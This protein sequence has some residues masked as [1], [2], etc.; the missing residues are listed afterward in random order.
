MTRSTPYEER[1]ASSNGNPRDFTEAERQRSRI[2]LQARHAAIRRLLKLHAV[3]FERLVN[4]ERKNR[5]LDPKQHKMTI[6]EMRRLANLAIEAG[7]E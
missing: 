6:A 5:G 4:E 2:A 1:I 7:L 3:D